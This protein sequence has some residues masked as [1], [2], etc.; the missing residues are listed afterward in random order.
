M[1][2]SFHRNI[3]S[4]VSLFSFVCFSKRGTSSPAIFKIKFQ[5]LLQDLSRIEE[6]FLFPLE[7]HTHLPLESIDPESWI[8]NFKKKKKKK[9]PS[10]PTS[11]N[12]PKHSFRE[13]VSGSKCNLI[14]SKLVKTLQRFL[15]KLINHHNPAVNADGAQRH[16]VNTKRGQTHTPPT[17]HSGISFS[18][19]SSTVSQCLFPSP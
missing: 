1:E 10:F 13:R 14:N 17:F 12:Q 11:N 9:I 15:L 16:L 6:R 5:V 18:P 7:T 4:V 19:V 3:E 8:L 2:T